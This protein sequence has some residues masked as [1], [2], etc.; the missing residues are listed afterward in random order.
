MRKILAFIALSLFA[1]TTWATGLEIVE[2]KQYRVLPE[3]VAYHGAKKEGKI[4]VTEFFSYACPHC[5]RMEPDLEKWIAKKKP[6]NVQFERAPVIFYPG[7]EELAKAYYVVSEL[8]MPEMNMAI[9]EAIHKD[10]KNLMSRDALIELF[11]AHKVSK[12]KFLKAYNS[13]GVQRSLDH[14]KVLSKDYMIQGVPSLVVNGKY[15]T[16]L[17]MA[18]GPKNM[19]EILEFLLAK[20]SKAATKK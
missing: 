17:S 15:M 8:K 12:D 7:W 9:F 3:A 13:F 6:A 5:Y 18:G 11:G 14:D 2:G 1:V 10:H 20:D 4:Q 16:D 19:L